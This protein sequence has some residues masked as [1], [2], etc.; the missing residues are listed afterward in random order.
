MSK[1]ITGLLPQ[2]LRYSGGLV[3]EAKVVIIKE[4]KDACLQG[5][6]ENSSKEVDQ[7]S[8]RKEEDEPAQYLG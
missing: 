2:R 8:Q 7:G 4:R 1:V 6:D 3:G 5:E